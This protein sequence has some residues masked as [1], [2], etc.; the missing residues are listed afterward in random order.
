MAVHCSLELKKKI[1]PCPIKIIN[2]GSFYFHSFILTPCLSQSLSSEA[3]ISLISLKFT[4]SNS[5]LSVSLSPPLAQLILNVGATVARRHQP[6]SR[7]KLPISLRP[8]SPIASDPLLFRHSTSGQLSLSSSCG[9][10]GF[11]IWV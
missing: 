7:P 3:L 4:L 6:T 10:L 5:H 1:I 11:L 2:V 9:C 8:T